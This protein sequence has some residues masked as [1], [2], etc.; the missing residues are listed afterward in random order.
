MYF[1][2]WCLEFGFE[3]AFELFIRRAYLARL[4]DE[5]NL[6]LDLLASILLLSTTSEDSIDFVILSCPV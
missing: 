6:D 3:L 5:D 2:D 1:L 4:T